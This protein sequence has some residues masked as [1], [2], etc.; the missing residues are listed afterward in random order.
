MKPQ[1]PP[2]ATEIQHFNQGIAFANA[3]RLKEAI[4]CYQ[5]A[6]A[7][8]PTFTV[9][10]YNFGTSLQALMRLDEAA[11]AYRQVLA[12]DPSFFE[13]HGNL[14]MV[15]QL[16][17]K[18]D[19]AIASYRKTL[20]INPNDALGHYNLATALRNHGKLDEAIASY[21]KAIALFP[22]YVDAYANMGEALF[23][24][25]KPDEA[26]ASYRQALAIAPDNAAANYKMGIFL[27]DAGELSAAIPYFQRS[28]MADW[29]ERTLYCLYKTEQYD[30]FKQG[31][32]VLM[33]EKNISPFLATLSSHY[34]TNFGEV[35]QYSFCKNP[36]DFVYHN[37]IVPLSQAGS[38]LL[39]DLLRDINFAE[40]AKRKQGRLHYGVQSSGNLFM[41]TEISFKTLASLITLEVEKYRAKFSGENCELMQ[42]FPINIEF[43]S[44]WYV[45]MSSGGHLTSHIHEEGWLSGSV[46]LSIPQQKTGT[47][48]GSIEFSTH[49][50]NYPQ[51]HQNFPVQAVAPIVGDIVLF[52]S[53]LFH[54]TIPFSSDEERICVAFD[55]KPA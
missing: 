43:S 45:K 55:V 6:I 49:G 44:S 51:K 36:L 1:R 16:Q 20:A 28:Q 32:Q 21:A 15:L 39:A 5:K 18:L 4:T 33:G 8:N 3:N 50:D 40:I 42:S 10:L 48:D 24:F 12:L 14:G 31:L 2:S 41:R 23:D 34:A 53:S 47:H 11:D 27:Y 46:Y 19:E 29:R 52:P 13:A 54:R 22:N 37:N 35:D 30:A 17:G 7:L 26:V 9:A 25:G 38:S